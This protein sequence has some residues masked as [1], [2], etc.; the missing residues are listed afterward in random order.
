MAFRM[1]WQALHRV[2]LPSFWPPSLVCLLSVLQ[3]LSL[4][5]D[6]ALR[7]LMRQK[8]V[9]VQK[10]SV[11]LQLTGVGQLL[12][13]PQNRVSPRRKPMVTLAT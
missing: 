5:S 13:R 1:T 9:A 11:V 12:R 7:R 8:V 6:W 3:R 4:Q 10:A 2:Q